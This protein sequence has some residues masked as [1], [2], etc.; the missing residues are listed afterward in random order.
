MNLVLKMKTEMKFK[1]KL[2]MKFK[3]EFQNHFYKPIARWNRKLKGV[4]KNFS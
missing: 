2:K 1:M 3:I 4:A